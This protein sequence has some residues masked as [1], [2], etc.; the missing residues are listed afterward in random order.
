MAKY[1]LLSKKEEKRNMRRATFFTLL[2]IAFAVG[3]IVWGIPSLIKMAVFFGNIKSSSTPIE[4]TSNLPP[5]PPFLNALPEATNSAKLNISGLALEGLTIKI[6]LT[7]SETQEVIA[8]K[9]GKFSTDELKLTL[10]NNEIYALAVDKEGNESASSEKISVWYENEPPELEISQ[11]NDKAVVN[12]EKGKVEVI[13]KTDPEASVQINDH[14]IILDKD[15]NFKYSLNLSLG[16]NNIKIIAKDIAG[17][18]TEKSL[19]V[20]YSP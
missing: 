1:S 4:K 7:G 5:S 10:G 11:P 2:T 15:G 13:G 14:L 20:N 6:F 17:N 19:T 8:D 3:V 16:D 9:D 18:Q 12:N